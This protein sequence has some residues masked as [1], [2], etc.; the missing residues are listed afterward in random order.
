MA[1]EAPIPPELVGYV[2]NPLAE[3]FTEE[4]FDD[5]HHVL[6]QYIVELAIERGSTEDPQDIVQDWEQEH[7]E[8]IENKRKAVQE[9]FGALLPYAFI[10][11]NLKVEYLRDSGHA[12]FKSGVFPEDVTEIMQEFLEIVAYREEL[13]GPGHKNSRS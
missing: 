4:I 1:S 2:R 8:E 11:S 9:Q 13:E 3:G 5:L 7:R 6:D 12:S 10:S